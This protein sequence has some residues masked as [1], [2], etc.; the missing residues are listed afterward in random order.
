MTSRQP[1]LTMYSSSITTTQHH[2]QL[3]V[4]LPHAS[5]QIVVANGRLGR[6]STSP[7]GGHNQHVDN[8]ER[9]CFISRYFYVFQNHYGLLS[10]EINNSK[11]EDAGL[12]SVRAG[13][14]E[15]EVTCSATLDV[16]GKC[17]RITCNVVYDVTST[18]VRRE[19]G[20]GVCGTVC[21]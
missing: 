19:E 13:N 17:I 16:T 7:E 10:L 11:R 6:C 12:Y 14:M 20:G 9:L 15:G 3:I 2:H 1:F 18:V 21:V 8:Q 4:E 5:S